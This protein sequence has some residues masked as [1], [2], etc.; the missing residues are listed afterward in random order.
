MKSKLLILCIWSLGLFSCLEDKTSDFELL[1][2]IRIDM[3]GLPKADVPFQLYQFD[4]LRIAPVIYREGCNDA[5]L[6]FEWRIQGNDVNRV[7]GRN[8]VLNAEI[9]EPERGEAYNI[10]LTVTDSTTMVQ[11]YQKWTLK[12][13]SIFRE[14]LIVADTRD[15]Q[16]TDLS[17]I[18]AMNFTTEFKDDKKDT[19][20]RDIY[21]RVNGEPIQGVANSLMMSAYYGASRTLTVLTPHSITRANPSSYDFMDNGRFAIAIKDELLPRDIKYDWRAP[22]E[23]MNI[24]GHLYPR[25]MQNSNFTFA[26]NML[27]SDM[28][29]YNITAY[30]CLYYLYW[31]YMYSSPEVGF[32]YDAIGKRFLIIPMQCGNLVTFKGAGSKYFDPTH[33]GD[34]V[35]IYMGEGI[36]HVIHAIMKDPAGNYSIYSL[37][38]TATDDGSD[39]IKAGAYRLNGCT[40][41]GQAGFWA[42]SRLE[43]LMYY[44]T[45]QTVYATSTLNTEDLTSTEPQYT[46]GTGEKITSLQVWGEGGTCYIPSTDPDAENGKQAIKSENRIVM[47]TT[48]NEQTKEGKIIAIPVERTGIGELMKDPA[49][50]VVYKGFGRIVAVGSQKP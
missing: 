50:H 15:E 20:F 18:M 3:T 22:F 49:Y 9:I 33:L 37:D 16:T 13:A 7:I 5:N 45:E 35:C 1:T 39:K 31:Y 24:N 26:L 34:Q 23:V 14:G 38:G 11:A 28:A 4:T 21:S 44:A 10:M 43:N 25:G 2:P 42:F 6:G 29:D 41:V 30:H 17:L 32:A 40:N 47:I 8:M 46:V 48:Y 19:I 27:S 36:N 12:V